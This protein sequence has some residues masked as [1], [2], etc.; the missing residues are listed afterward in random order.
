MKSARRPDLWRCC[1]CLSGCFKYGGDIKTNTQRFLKKPIPTASR[2]PWWPGRT[3]RWAQAG[4]PSK[5]RVLFIHGSP[6]SWD[7]WAG[8]LMDPALLAQACL[9]APDRLGYGGS[10]NGCVVPSLQ[11]QSD[12][13]LPALADAS[14]PVI[15]VGHS[16]GGPIAARFVMD[17]PDKVA[18]LILVAGSIDPAQEKILWYQYPASWLPFRWMLPSALDVCNRE[19]MPLK[20]ELTADAAALVPRSRCRWSSIQ[21]HG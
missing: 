21:G 14:G 12:A 2:M 15:V 8:F 7:A 3:V 5:P 16:L 11:E 13:L 18:A 10:C 20:G 1:P 6:G 19:L 17:H 4:D 9:V